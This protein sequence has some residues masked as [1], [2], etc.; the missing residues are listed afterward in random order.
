MV[1]GMRPASSSRHSCWSVDAL[2]RFSDL[3]VDPPPGGR[4]HVVEWLNSTLGECTARIVESPGTPNQTLGPTF[5]WFGPGFSIVISSPRLDRPT[6][7]PPREG[8]DIRV[9]WGVPGLGVVTPPSSDKP[10]IVAAQSWQGDDCPDDDGFIRGARFNGDLTV[11]QSTTAAD[12]PGSPEQVRGWL[13]ACPL[14]PPSITTAMSSV[15]DHY[16]GPSTWDPDAG[17]WVVSTLP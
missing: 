4:F 3:N 8:W 12:R 13:D 17:R 10:V 7:A 14:V 5:S 16:T 11:Q 6:H 15:I 1:V 9:K 2:N